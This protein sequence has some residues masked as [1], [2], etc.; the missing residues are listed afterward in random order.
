[1]FDCVFVFAD[2]SNVTIGVSVLFST[3]IVVLSAAIIM[4]V[5]KIIHIKKPYKKG[6][7]VSACVL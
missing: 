4:L 3:V 2:N 5:I 1:M 6:K 7:P